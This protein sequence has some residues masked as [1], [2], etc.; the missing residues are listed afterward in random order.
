MEALRR[1]LE[2]GEGRRTERITEVCGDDPEL[3]KAVEDLLAAEPPPVLD[4]RGPADA[5]GTGGDPGE[6]AGDALPEVEVPGFRITRL[7]GSGGMGMV[8]AAEQEHPRRAVALKVIRGGGFVTQHQIRLLKR[9][10]QI[11]ARLRHPSIATIH[12]VGQT[13][14]GLPYFAMELVRGEELTSFVRDYPLEG[15]NQRTNLHLRLE[16]FLRIVDAVV[17]AH[18]RG[19]LHR[20]I[21]PG[22]VLVSRTTGSEPHSPAGARNIQIKLLD[23]GI[24][25]ILDPEARITM[26]TVA[27]HILGTLDYMSP[28]QA[29]GESDL[30]DGR[31]DVYS[32]GVILYELLTDRLPLDV[33]GLP[34]HRAVRRIC[35]E[36]PP[37]AGSARTLLRGDLETILATALE[38]DPA[39][40]Y[41]TAAALA[42][43]MS[44]YLEKRPI[45]ART[46]S[47]A[48]QMGKLLARYRLQAGF[49]AALFV[50]ALSSTAA[51]SILWQHQRSERKHAERAEAEARERL[52]QSSLAEARSTRLSGHPG[53]KIDALAAIATAAEI[54]P[55][56]DLRNETVAAMA[57]FDLRRM[58]P[59]LRLGMFTDNACVGVDGELTTLVDPQPGGALAVRDAESGEVLREIPGTGKGR[60]LYCRCDDSGR[61]LAVK[62]IDDLDQAPSVR[63]HTFRLWDA[64]SGSLLLETP[65]PW[66]PAFDLS[67]DGRWLVV[68]GGQDAI[69]VYSLEQGASPE[70][71]TTWRVPHPRSVS[72]SADARFV[73]IG[74]SRLVQVRDLASGEVVWEQDL[75]TSAWVVAW[76]AQGDRLA[77][78]CGRK[79]VHLY[80]GMGTALGLLEGHGAQ[81]VELAFHESGRWLVSSGWDW[82]TMIW[83]MTTLEKVLE[84]T[85]YLSGMSRHGDRL[86]IQYGDRLTRYELAPPRGVQHVQSQQRRDGIAHECAFS[87]DGRLLASSGADGLM[88]WELSDP[89]AGLKLAD[90][91]D[92][93]LFAPDSKRLYSVGPEALRSWNLELGPTGL[94]ADPTGTSSLK[95]TGVGGAAL[96]GDGR[97]MAIIG[98]AGALLILD[99]SG[100]A[101]PTVLTRRAQSWHVA[102]DSTGRWV[103]AGGLM[104]EVTV[105]DT[106]SRRAVATLRL[107]GNPGGGVAVSSNDRWLIFA[108]SQECG[109]WEVGSWRRESAFEPNLER[110]PLRGSVALSPDGTIAAI[111]TL[112]RVRLVAVPTGVELCSLESP[113]KDS[114]TSMDFDARGSRLAVAYAGGRIEVW[115]LDQVLE[116]LNRVGL[117]WTGETPLPVMKPSRSGR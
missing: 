106:R 85:G 77:V 68:G 63:T 2:A 72:I 22:N 78:G 84:T 97:L 18:E 17:H 74:A 105:W 41:Q 13:A 65:T 9:E 66:Q 54:R 49:L 108:T 12:E 33:T 109:I 27:G 46:P 67:A 61:L 64:R 79:H 58:G 19:I 70:L 26:G 87:P 6:E 10:A 20:D 36:E 92:I 91:S 53:H 28:E 44:R 51:M 3:R 100:P 110:E 47:L 62:Y 23:F 45:L 29:R 16:I 80:D 48:Y 34:L 42:D 37:R 39:R 38:K 55:S 14:E 15:Q 24:A 60:G 1:V 107:P 40:R 115:D 81:V 112:S 95:I 96:S 103:A 114:V 35:E 99:P 71:V 89:P 69:S 43:D 116:E 75:P 113:H 57:L 101:G 88:L 30:V 102:T 76:S 117:S 11:L 86:A 32:L 104:P 82:A 25:R 90:E 73:A 56:I 5:L 21:K 4:T 52:W 83:D 50:L 59:D 8:F 111:A 93:P 7:L 94:S 98:D 31:S